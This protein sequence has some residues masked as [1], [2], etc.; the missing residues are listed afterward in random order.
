MLRKVFSSLLLIAATVIGLGAFGHGSAIVQVHAALA[1]FPIDPHMIGVLDIVWFFVSGSMLA[2]GIA[3]FWSWFRYRRGDP[4][5]F[6]VTDLIGILYVLTGIGGKM[7]LPA[8]PFF[9]MFFVLGVV[10]L[11]STAVLRRNP[12]N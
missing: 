1:P 7:R 2:F 6:W 4:K 12:A 10:L 8:D 3:I 9:W 11:S 5:S